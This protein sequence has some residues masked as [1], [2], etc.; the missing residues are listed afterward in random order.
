MTTHLLGKPGLKSTPK[1]SQKPAAASPKPGTAEHE[2]LER[3]ITENVIGALTPLLVDMKKLSVE[4]TA[5]PVAPDTGLEPVAVSTVLSAADRTWIGDRVLSS[6]TDALQPLMADVQ[7][8]LANLPAP[9]STQNQSFTSGANDTPAKSSGP[10]AGAAASG[11]NTQA[12]VTDTL[13][14]KDVPIVV[15]ADMPDNSDK[16][17]AGEGTSTQSIEQAVTKN[18]MTAL[19]PLLTE[20]QKLVG[21]KGGGLSAGQSGLEDAQL[22]A[23]SLLAEGMKLAQE[24]QRRTMLRFKQKQAVAARRLGGAK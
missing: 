12:P 10:E 9:P 19:S 15:G 4:P 8:L 20:L 21:Q 7:K 23:Q 18:V 2:Y 1:R 14:D 22:A 17:A 5:D 3:T 13:H 24:K 6:V 11:A 16:A